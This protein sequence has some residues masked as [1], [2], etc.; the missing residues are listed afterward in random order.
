MMSRRFFIALSLSLAFGSLAVD[1]HAQAWPTKP[2]RLVIGY[3]PGGP[4]DSIARLITPVLGKELGQPVIVDNK[5]GAAGA[6]GVASTV[7]AEPDGYTFGI[8]VLGVL[9]VAP[10]VGK[11]PF[12][13][14]D[15]SYVTMLTQSPHVLVMNPKQGMKDLK[16]FID[17]ARK[18]PGKLNYGSP[19]QGSSTHLDGELLQEEAKIDI[20]HVPYK[21]GAAAV[22]ALL[23]GEIQL[24]AAEISA[25]LPLQ[26]KLG[27]V[28]VMGDKRAPQLPN[29]PTTV[30]LGYPGVVASSMY[31]IIAP[32]K[33]PPAITDRFRAAVHKALALPEVRDRLLA[34]G[35]TP[36]PTTGEVYRK[37]MADESVKWG[38]VIKKRNI[39]FD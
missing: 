9:A 20:V 36:M 28:A 30:E 35:Q 22:T 34:Q 26:S 16:S 33:T 17:A 15:V 1:A 3:P 14:E 7:Q 4:V 18:A 13:V 24:L 10:H 25:A 6:L 2:I 31:G 27:I 5:P 12:K 19:G 23:G 21:G 37:L 11:Q 29:V 39:K 32:A 38:A 8:G